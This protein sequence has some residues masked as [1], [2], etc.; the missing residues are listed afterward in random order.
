MHP[1][2]C[3]AKV[4]QCIHHED[5]KPEASN[6]FETSLRISGHK[7]NKSKDKEYFSYAKV[8]IISL[9]SEDALDLESLNV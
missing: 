1:L 6:T 3:L 8:N 7:G 4:A 5:R 9:A 2:S